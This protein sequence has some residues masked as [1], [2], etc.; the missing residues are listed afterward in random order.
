MSIYVPIKNQRKPDSA[1]SNIS[2]INLL[3]KIVFSSG[4]LGVILFS[5]FMFIGLIPMS[6]ALIFIGISLFFGFIVYYKLSKLKKREQ[7]KIVKYEEIK[8]RYDKLAFLLEKEEFGCKEISFL[9]ESKSDKNNN[10]LICSLNI[11]EGDYLTED[12]SVIAFYGDIDSP[13]SILKSSYYGIVNKI[14]RIKNGNFYIL[15]MCWQINSEY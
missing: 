4:L 3:I 10:E 15:L 7:S 12:V 6:M 1:E 2:L 13:S 14:E 8:S 9:I 5:S 11:E